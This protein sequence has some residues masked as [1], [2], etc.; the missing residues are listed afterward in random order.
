[1]TP[2]QQMPNDQFSS[3]EPSIRHLREDASHGGEPTREEIVR[4][5]IQLWE[6]DDHPTS[7]PE[8]YCPEAERRLRRDAILTSH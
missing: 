1:M 4:L 7:T 2:D 8:D 5:A 3:I 6:N